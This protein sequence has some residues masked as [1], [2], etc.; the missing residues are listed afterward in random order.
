ME[1][2]Q[3]KLRK[4]RPEDAPLM[5]EWMH[6][7]SVVQDLKTDFSKKSIQDCQDFITAAQDETR[8]L[9]LAIAD[10]TDQYMGTVSL[11]HIDRTNG[12]AEFAITVR[13]CAMGRGFSKWGMKEI[14]DLGF[15]KLGLKT[16]V[17]CVSPLNKRACRFYEKNGYVQTTEIPQTVLQYYQDGEPYL[18]FAKKA[19]E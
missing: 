2:N 4:L 3:M 10:E 12:I 11:K 17:W 1:G 15:R 9:H 13:K 5:Y 19:G 14:L 8:D 6:D 7:K 16:I 18:W